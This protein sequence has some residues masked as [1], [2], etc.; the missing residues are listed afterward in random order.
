[1]TWL[2]LL[3]LAIVQG[4]TEFLPVSSSAHLILPAQILNWPDQ[5]PL[6]DLMAHLGSL[7]AVLIY[8]RRDVRRMLCGGVDLLSFDQARQS[9]ER[10]RLTSYILIATPPALLAGLAMNAI[11]WDEAIRSPAII[12]WTMIIFGIILWLADV[13]GKKVKTIEGMNWKAAFLIGLAQIIAFIPGT[14]RS[15]ITMTAARALGYTR[16]ESARFS[17]L[18]AIPI[19]GAGGCFA[20]IKLLRS[21][22]GN[23][24]WMDGLVVAGLS[25]IAAYFAIYVF[26]RL[27]EKISFLPFMIY[28]VALGVILLWWIAQGGT[29]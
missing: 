13:F 20:F 9:S 27:I 24:S 7:G 28:R 4:L 14:S 8:Y 16:T 19:I 10:A 6:I 5:G 12:A 18:M 22:G 23:A 21:G 3:I 17:M 1:M 2:H 29:A 15:G 11:G 25:L 26:M